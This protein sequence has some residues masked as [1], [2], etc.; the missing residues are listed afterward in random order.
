[1]L[2]K[3]LSIKNKIFITLTCIL[4]LGFTIAGFLVLS[5]V[6]NNITI[7]MKKQLHSETQVIKSFVKSTDKISQQ[8]S[9]KVNKDAEAMLLKSVDELWSRI[10]SISELISIVDN[11][12]IVANSATNVILKTKFHK[13]GYA[14]ALDMNGKLVVHPKTQGKDIGNQ[15]HIKK[16]LSKDRG[17]IRYQRSTEPGKPWVYAAFKS[18][19]KLGWTFV[20]TVSEDELLKSSKFMEESLM[21][22]IRENIKSIK[23]GT[24]GYFY[25]IDT[26]GNII[27]HPT[28]EDKS[29]SNLEFVKEMIKNK[30]GSIEYEWKGATK[31][32]SYS[33][34][35]DRNWIIAGGSY[36]D[37]FI[38]DT[39]KNI[40]WDFILTSLIVISISLLLISFIFN[41]SVIKPLGSLE[42]I[43]SRISSGDLTATIKKQNDDEIGNIIEHVDNM[44]YQMNG[45]LY[46]VSQ[47]T[48]HVHSSA[49]SLSSSSNEMS[50]GSEKQAEQVTQ[51]EVAVH[52]MTAT[53]QEIS[54]NVEEVTSEVGHIKDSASSGGE[55]LEAT[56]NSINN[57]STAVI[58][59]ASSIKELGEASEQIG[60]ILQV[61]SDIADQTNLLALNAAIEAA[62]AGDHGRG[63]AVV[64]DEVRK[65]A[66]RTVK[67]TSEIDSM[68]KSIQKE[69]INSVSQ[70][71][72]GVELAEEGG[73]MVS[74][75][76]MSLGEIIG[77]VVDIADKISSVAASVEQQSATSQEISNSMSDIASIAQESSSIA[78]E[79]NH[80]S[81]TLMKL[82]DELSTVVQQFN[83]KDCN[84][85]S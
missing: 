1:M 28:S 50:I 24:S 67:A 16:I 75:L 2:K 5:G 73:M 78:S 84:N 56:V 83:L 19:P 70:M 71:D 11:Y 7:E 64:A 48:N 85:K 51:V 46:K 26:K 14:Y 12:D 39:M 20:I 43:F 59:T 54:M 53:I 10:F 74:N 36:L 41:I 6:K 17:I 13:T 30:D 82:S 4:I 9:K 18:F 77:G 62:R 61:I 47:S 27:I 25:V 37:E 34:Y 33:Y 79:N 42:K 31:I 72:K 45:A 68:I 29:I 44:L 52:E 65:L 23:I 35:K 58:K 80:Q 81:D 32:V 63:F 55:I 49:E 38:G 66:E 57:L 60:E 22:D 40:V 3:S 15:P 21:K 76:Q 8:L 69:V